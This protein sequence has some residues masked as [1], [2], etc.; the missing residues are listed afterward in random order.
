[1]GGVF[2]KKIVVIV[3]FLSLAI[4]CAGILE[5]MRTLHSGVIR[6]HVVG[7]S[8]GTVDQ[9][10]KLEVKDAVNTYLANILLEVTS[11]EEVKSILLHEMPTIKAVAD[12][13][14][15]SRGFRDRVTVTLEKEAFPIREYDTF[16]LP[17]GVYDALRIR[18]GAGAGKNW[19]CV[20]FP[21]LCLPATGEE[22]KDISAGAG[23]SDTLYDTLTGNSGYEIR[24]FL[25]DW[26]GQLQNLWFDQ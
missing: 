12:Q 22:L 7:A 20:V 18:I 14:L 6:L 17:S 4:F 2:M 25:L 9:E 19:W 23:F 24:F 15:D 13:V 1:M 3:V 11:V 21:S 5:D 26:L 8:D 16:T 10:V